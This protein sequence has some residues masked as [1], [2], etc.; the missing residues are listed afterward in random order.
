[1][2][3][4]GVSGQCGVP[5]SCGRCGVSETDLYM[6]NGKKER[7]VSAVYNG[8]KMLRKAAVAP[9]P[10]FRPFCEI[11]LSGK[12]GSDVQTKRTECLSRSDGSV[13]VWDEVQ[14]K[15]LMAFSLPGDSL[16]NCTL[17]VVVNDENPIA[18]TKVGECDLDLASIENLPQVRDRPGKEVVLKLKASAEDPTYCGEIVLRLWM[19]PRE[20]FCLVSR[21]RG[22][23]DRDSEVG[24]TDLVHDRK[25]L[26]V[27]TAMVFIFL[28]GG[29]AIFSAIESVG[30]LDSL[31]FCM[32]VVTTVGYGDISPKT[33]WGKIYVC[34]YG[35]LGISLIGSALGIMAGWLAD[36]L[37][38]MGEETVSAITKTLNGNLSGSEMKGSGC[39]NSKCLRTMCPSS[40]GDPSRVLCCGVPKPLCCHPPQGASRAEKI[41]FSRKIN[42]IVAV[43]LYMSFNLVSAALY[44]SVEDSLSFGDAVYM[45]WITS[46]TIGFGDYSPQSPAGRGIA[47]F[48]LAA[49][50]MTTANLLANISAVF[51]ENRR[52]RLEDKMEQE[53][54][55]RDLE[56][57]QA[58][59]VSRPPPSPSRNVS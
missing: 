33:G 17:R 58:E 10:L 35:L 13:F 27:C 48:W 11:S 22:L 54:L 14:H 53:K 57:V 24:S 19:A 49:S 29:A 44:T 20:L 15:S 36:A 3:I 30:F 2:P 59:K 55:S 47:I 40:D 46:L 12:D 18:T 34:F 26:I 43:I 51:I 41:I 28:F 45:S 1:M 52:L 31:Y 4:F 7:V 32:T 56:E 39:R 23:R 5:I 8:P 50:T 6:P 42:L 16:G 21:G 25:S 38:S 37:D 9:V